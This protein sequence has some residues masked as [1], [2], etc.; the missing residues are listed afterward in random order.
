MNDKNLTRGCV[1]LR[2][3]L[4][5]SPSRTQASLAEDLEISAAAVSNIINGRN[6]PSRDCLLYTSP[7]PRRAALLSREPQALDGCALRRAGRLARE[8]ADAVAVLADI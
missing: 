7:S 6:G 4:A 2:A 8:S 1:L 3:W 5:E